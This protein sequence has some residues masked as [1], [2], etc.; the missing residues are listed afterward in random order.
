MQR[1][2]FL[3][4]G[5]AASTISL[6]RADAASAQ[7][8]RGPA[9]DPVLVPTRADIVPGEIHVLP[10]AFMLYWTMP[11][12]RAMRYR[13]GVGRPGLYESGEFYVGAKKEWPS[14][15]PTASMIER[16]PEKYEQYKDGVPGGPENPLGARAL[17][18]FQPGR[19]DT[20]LRIHG[21]NA[22]GTIG[23]AVSNG[24]ARLINPEIIDLYNRVPM[25]SRV[26]LYP[27][28]A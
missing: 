11:G 9:F 8:A 3:T 27:K 25:K 13:I 17:Y 7:S 14:W 24:C 10:D 18:L 1:R 22:P 28:A 16:E 26:L 20:F 4:A 5:L 23:S 6:F 12:G 19:G 15:T 2:H 21:T